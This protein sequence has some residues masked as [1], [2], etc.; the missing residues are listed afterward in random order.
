MGDFT[1]LTVWQRAHDLCLGV[2]RATASW[3]NHE[4]F[5]LTSQTRRA[6][7]SIAG[8]LA[9]GCGK[10]SDAELARH[11][12]IALGSANELRYYLILAR[13]LDYIGLSVYEELQSEVTEARRMLAS[14]ERVSGNAAQRQ[15]PTA[16]L[17]RKVVNA[18]RP[19]HSADG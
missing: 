17:R 3:P 11:C 9:E 2:Y 18:P 7:Y 10:N 8:N 5:S 13:D 19:Q 12:R 16:R 6:A 14:L 1:K 4:L 15:S